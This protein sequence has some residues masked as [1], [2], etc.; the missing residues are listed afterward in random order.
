M[1]SFDL[2]SF[3]EKLIPI[4][5]QLI[6][7][8]ILQNYDYSLRDLDRPRSRTWRTSIVPRGNLFVLFRKRKQGRE[9]EQKDEEAGC[10]NVV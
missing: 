6:M 1:S 5:L 2:Q 9:Q 8:Q 4:E 7:S 3:E 10:S